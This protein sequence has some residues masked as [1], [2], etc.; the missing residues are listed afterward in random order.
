MAVGQWYIWDDTLVLLGS[1]RNDVYNR[2]SVGAPS[3]A[4]VFPG[5]VE[6]NYDPAFLIGPTNY[7]EQADEDTTSWSVMLHTPQFIKDWLSWGAGPRAS[8]NLILAGKAHAVLN[9]Q[10]AVGWDDIDAVVQS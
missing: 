3:A 7:V 9:G 1:W 5:R 4:A 8:M 10:F 6:D 2:A